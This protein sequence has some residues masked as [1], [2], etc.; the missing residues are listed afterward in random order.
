MDLST[1]DKLYETL[2]IFKRLL[3]IVLTL[4]YNI[5]YNIDIKK[6]KYYTT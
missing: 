3:F 1:Y 4:T 6:F 5:M 2:N